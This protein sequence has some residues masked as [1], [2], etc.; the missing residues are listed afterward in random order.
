MVSDR[1]TFGERLKRQRERRGIPLEA[2]SESTK[3]ATSLFVG[4]ENGDCSRWPAGLYSRAYIR[5]YAEAIGLNADE[6]VEDFATVFSGKVSPTGSTTRRCG[7]RP[8]GFPPGACRGASRPF[9]FRPRGA[10]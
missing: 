2:I 10:R 4:L 5:A 6:A 9:L 8:A 1:R 7:G 3:I